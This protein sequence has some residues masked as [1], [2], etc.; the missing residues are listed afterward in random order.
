M[1][2][3]RI[4]RVRARYAEGDYEYDIPEILEEKYRYHR[5]LRD[6]LSNMM[7]YLAN[8]KHKDLRDGRDIQAMKKAVD[9]MKTALEK[10]YIGGPCGE[11]EYEQLVLVIRLLDAEITGYPRYYAR[12]TKGLPPFA[13]THEIIEYTLE[14]I[15]GIVKEQKDTIRY[16]QE[17]YKKCLERS[18][19]P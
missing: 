16:Y 17:K 15:L 11:T 1:I 10:C 13:T 3:D 2:R 8:Y 12:D 18:P 6:F 4:R 5:F 7:I 9:G 19:E 14:A